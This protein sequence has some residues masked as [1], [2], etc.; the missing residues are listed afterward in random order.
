MPRKTSS[1]GGERTPHP[2]EAGESHSSVGNIPDPA[3][4]ILHI[5]VRGRAS[6]YPRGSATTDVN[7]L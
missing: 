4:R 6:A 5:A 3:Q 2:V 7:N 1:A